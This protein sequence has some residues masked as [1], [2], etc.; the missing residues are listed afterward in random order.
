[1]TTLNTDLLLANISDGIIITTASGEIVSYNLTA[2]VFIDPDMKMLKTGQNIHDN[3]D[4]FKDVWDDLF[5]PPYF[6]DF[7][8]EAYGK[9][10][11]IRIVANNYDDNNEVE[12]FCIIIT[13]EHQNMYA[14]DYNQALVESKNK[15]NKDQIASIQNKINIINHELQNELSSIGLINQSLKD[16]NKEDKHYQGIENALNQIKSIS[17]NLEDISKPLYNLGSV[18]N[19]VELA[20]VS[21]VAND[22][23]NE[24]EVENF[25]AGILVLEQARNFSIDYD[26]DMSEFSHKED[27]KIQMN[28]QALRTALVNILKNASESISNNTDDNVK[29]NGKILIKPHVDDSDNCFKIDITNNGGSMDENLILQ[30]NAGEQIKSTKILGKGIGISHVINTLIPYAGSL[31]FVNLSET[32]VKI[33]LSFPK[34]IIL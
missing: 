22:N 7:F 29:N 11:N 18:S 17:E 16:K 31:K 15:E 34:T 6:E 13:L 5:K 9:N 1:M 20:G 4:S 10:F 24:I 23:T 27:L 12:A 21:H 3:M 2:C 33:S 8:M 30:L 19:I 26:L 25:I 28:P 32:N 14:K